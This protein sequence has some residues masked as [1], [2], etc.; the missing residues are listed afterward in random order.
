VN[1]DNGKRIVSNVVDR[2]FVNTE[3]DGNDV[4]YAKD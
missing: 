2:K 4:E 3:N 1:T